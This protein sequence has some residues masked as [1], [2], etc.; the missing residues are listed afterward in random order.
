MI[1]AGGGGGGGGMR[2]QKQLQLQTG[3][4][5]QPLHV[6]GVLV[7]LLRRPLNPLTPTCI[8]N[9][10]DTKAPYGLD[11]S[12]LHRK[13]I[14][15]AHQYRPPQHFHTE[16]NHTTINPSPQPPTP[17][18]LNPRILISPPPLSPLH[19]PLRA[20]PPQRPGLHSDPRAPTVLS[21]V[22]NRRSNGA[23]RAQHKRRTVG[24]SPRPSHLGA[25][26]MESD[27]PRGGL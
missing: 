4:R 1:G 9:Q 16:T 13:F 23:N 11:M 2:V 22:R 19:L 27:R 14:S 6:S 5:I 3:F 25:V 7:Q 20:H 24:A 21:P 26:Q 15:R 10:H 17:A 12:V 18:L 8:P